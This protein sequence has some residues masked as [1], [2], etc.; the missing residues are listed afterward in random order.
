MGMTVTPEQLM[1]AAMDIAAASVDGRIKPADIEA[2]VTG[3]CRELFGTVHGPGDELW[4]LHL[5]VTRQALH[6]GALSADEL[7][8]WLA[9]MRTREGTPIEAAPVSWIEQALAD[10]ADD[11]A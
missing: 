6:A 7:A 3:R 5:D 8:E 10:G 4:D 9:V 2:E 1:D 11:D